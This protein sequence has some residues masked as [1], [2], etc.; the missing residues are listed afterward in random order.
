MCLS[1]D[2]KAID[3]QQL[4]HSIVRDFF[5]NHEAI[6]VAKCVPPTKSID[7]L[8]GVINLELEYI[9][10]NDKGIDKMF[11]VFFSIDEYAK[12]SLHTLQVLAG[13]SMRYATFLPSMK[14]FVNGFYMESKKFHGG[15]SQLRSLSSLCKFHI[16]IWRFMALMLYIDPETFRLPLY[17]MRSIDRQVPRLLY[18][19]D[20]S[21]W[22]LGVTFRHPRNTDKIIFHSALNLPF[23]GPD[24]SNEELTAQ[25]IPIPLARLPDYHNAY[26]YFGQ[27][28]GALIAI[29][30]INIGALHRFEDPE[31]PYLAQIEHSGN[32]ASLAL[33]GDNVAALKWARDERANSTAAF[34]ANLADAWLRV[35]TQMTLVSATHLAGVAMG[36][37]DNL[38]RNK[39]DIHNELV[40]SEFVD[41][42][43]I[44]PRIHELFTLFDPTIG[45]NQDKY[46]TAFFKIHEI[47]HSIIP[48]PSL[49]NTT[50]PQN[51]FMF[52]DDLD[53]PDDI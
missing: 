14:P 18:Q 48:T 31:G 49:S 34:N 43:I 26:E 36:S 1:V 30:L 13:V 27:L 42:H 8:G 17:R 38:S 15:A 37:S 44:F 39:A 28:F 7:I 52:S 19:P 47:L 10:P 21:P 29:H 3:D 32:V 20:A 25:G 46:H 40:D 51:I 12:H 35:H 11:Y 41:P 45:Q 9:R 2:E 4:V 16:E 24:L 22:K 53:D 33:I 5:N 50:K 23:A 6:K